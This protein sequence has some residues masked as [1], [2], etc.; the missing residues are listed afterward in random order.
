MFSIELFYFVLGEIG[1]RNIERM[2]EG[3]TCICLL[4][5]AQGVV[6]TY[7]LPG[8]GLRTYV[9]ISSLNSYNSFEPLVQF[10]L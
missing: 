9:C 7:P 3:R 5:V 1:G 8:P 6:N 2:G 4:I 10:E